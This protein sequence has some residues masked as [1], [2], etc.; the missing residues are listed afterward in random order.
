VIIEKPGLLGCCALSLGNSKPTF[1]RSSF[2]TSGSNYPTTRRK[3]PEYLLPQLE[4]RFADNKTHQ[5]PFQSVLR[6][7][8]SMT[9]YLSLAVVTLLSLSLSR[10]LRWRPDVWLF[11]VPRAS[12]KRDRVQIGIA[13][14]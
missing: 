7:A 13:E 6:K 11:Y 2:E 3:N 14:K 12:E 9:C 1:R 5:S 10:L 8:S 4:N